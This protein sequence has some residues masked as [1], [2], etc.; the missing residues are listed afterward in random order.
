MRLNEFAETFLEVFSQRAGRAVAMAVAFF[1]GLGFLTVRLALSRHWAGAMVCLL[2][3]AAPLLVGG[4]IY[5]RH[6]RA[7]LEEA[8]R[9]RFPLNLPYR[10]S[11]SKD[12]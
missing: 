8:Q 2:L 11:S 10:P 6:R 1:I 3:M 5:R 12:G 9:A 7:A 4:L